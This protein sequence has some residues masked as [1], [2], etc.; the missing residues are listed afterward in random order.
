MRKTIISLIGGR[1]RGVLKLSSLQVPIT[2]I[3]RILYYYNIYRYI[4]Y[5]YNIHN[6][7]HLRSF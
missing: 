4:I 1:K 3:I 2:I 7:F 5:K 6:D